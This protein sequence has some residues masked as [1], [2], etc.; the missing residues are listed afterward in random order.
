MGQKNSRIKKYY[1]IYAVFCV[2]IFTILLFCNLRTP[3]LVDDYAYAFSF[4]SSTGEKQRIET[5]SDIFS[6][7]NGHRLTMN[8]R[9]VAHFFVQL[10][11]LLPSWVF[12]LLNTAVFV[13]EIVLLTELSA[14]YTNAEKRQKRKAIILLFS[15]AAVWIFQPVFGQVNLWL[16]GSINYL[17]AA[18]LSLGLMG[19][20]FKIYRE[21][22]FHMNLTEKMGFVI[23]SFIVGAWCENA[24]G[25]LLLLEIALILLMKFQQKRKIP[26]IT[27]LSFELTLAGFLLMV[28]A[29]AELK[30]KTGEL[31]LGHLLAMVSDLFTKFQ[32]FW[33]LW[34]M[35]G[36]LLVMAICTKVKKETLLISVLI[37][38]MA[39]AAGLCLI[40]GSYI[41]ERSLF[42]TVVLLV[43]ACGILIN[44]LLDSFKI[45]I[46]CMICLVC[47]AF[48]YY[49]FTG[50]NDINTCYY[51]FVNNEQ[52]IIA[53]AE[54]GE[55]TAEISY[56]Y[57]GT[58]YT[59]SYGLQY[60][61]QSDPESW[62]NDSMAVYYGV[63]TVKAKN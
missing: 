35:V 27:I 61:D 20:Y 34:A 37:I 30:N 12:E 9:I 24:A 8:G 13:L 45:Q 42:F 52:E 60:L 44:A 50:V 21:E 38:L 48:P 31:N 2:A 51:A 57:P 40:F 28:T 54:A 25:A 11:V 36:I 17:W 56:V 63:E 47:L 39:L 32:S 33:L 62:P 55:D 5:V 29:P 10:F 41:T 15:F 22:N 6:S 14:V 18:V 23:Y 59:A 26:L 19:V 1:L 43:F 3:L 4:Q 16:D 49:F 58:K 53:C 7:M 46:L